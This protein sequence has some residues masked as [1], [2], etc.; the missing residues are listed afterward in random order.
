MVLGSELN[1]YVRTSLLMKKNRTE[2]KTHL[3][4]RGYNQ[5]F[6]EKELQK[7]DK[8]E[9]ENLLNY[10]SKKK[11]MERVPLVVTFSKGLPDVR[12]IL[13]KH[14]PKLHTSDRMKDIFPIQ[15]ILAYKRDNNLQDILVHKKH[16]K[17]F[18]QKPKV[19]E[20]CGSNCALC[21]YLQNS[22]TITNYC[23]EVYNVRN[24]INCKTENVVYA[25][26]C[27]KCDAYIYVGE[28]GD[29]LYQRQLLNISRI[30]TK[31]KIDPVAKHFWEN[32]HTI[33]DFRVQGIEKLCGDDEYRKT[34]E[35]LWKSKM[36]TYKPYGINTKE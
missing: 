25:I 3:K 21:P 15:P 33:A 11:K 10:R 27:R 4:N 9:R 23:G 13:Q 8:V 34:H 14:M 20:P 7:V 30:R 36:R 5:R 2:I 17:M 22:E 24:Y 26:F 18:F 28:T 12:N 19:C 1:G 29:T 31:S 32:D 6:I 35:N 16:N